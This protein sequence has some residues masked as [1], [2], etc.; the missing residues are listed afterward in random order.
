[1]PEGVGGWIA[2]LLEK[3]AM[4]IGLAAAGWFVSTG[5]ERDKQAAEQARLA[6]AQSTEVTRL[7]MERERIDQM[8]LPRAMDVL[9]GK[10]SQER[11]WGAEV[12]VEERRVFRSHWIDTYNTYA[13]VDLDQRAIAVL[14]EAGLGAARGPQIAT[15]TPLPPTVAAPPAAGGQAVQ[16][17]GWVSVGRPGSTRYADQNFD[18]LGGAAFAA[19]GALPRDTVMRARWTVNLR[20]STEVAP[21]EGNAP[22]GVLA[23]GQCV[24]VLES[25]PNVRGGTWAFVDLED[26]APGG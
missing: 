1:M 25:R 17:D 12:S 16:G 7:A 14:M 8:I 19:N 21:G 5:L 3:C 24:R 6:F 9:F 26:C 2:F 15:G 4:P 22:R 11:I 23:A 20:P 10:D 18:L 13:R